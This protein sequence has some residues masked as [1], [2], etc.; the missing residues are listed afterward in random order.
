MT[1]HSKKIITILSCIILF[2]QAHAIVRGVNGI[3]FDHD[4]NGVID[5]TLN[6]TG[7]SIGSVISS[8]NLNI[9][10][11][12]AWSSK[13]IQQNT[14]LGDDSS[15]MILMDTSSGCL[16][17]GL[18]YAANVTGR[19][20]KVKQS[21]GEHAIYLRTKGESIGSGLL[22]NLSITQNS[23][24][25]PYMDLYSDGQQWHILQ[26]H[27]NVQTLVNS[28][29]LIGYWRC[30]ESSGNTIKDLSAYGNDALQQ[31]GLDLSTHTRNG[32]YERG[33]DFGVSTTQH[34]KVVFSDHVNSP[35]P[36]KAFTISLWAFYESLSASSNTLAALGSNSSAFGSVFLRKDADGWFR[37][38]LDD[39][40][41]G[42]A[43]GTSQT[44]A[45]IN[46][47]IHIVGTYDGT[48]IKLYINGQLNSDPSILSAQTT[49]DIYY[50]YAANDERTFIIGNRKSGTISA[51]AIVD[52]VQ[53]Y[54]RALSD[55]EIQLLYGSF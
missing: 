16:N 32:R 22:S 10:G 20:L 41:E 37:L 39:G 40:S 47:W 24:V 34:L 49:Q 13:L 17:L 46:N 52:E 7:L 1:N 30:D 14:W 54:N 11:S 27:G 29:N 55:Q 38:R 8:S 50:N 43:V 42:F 5:M 12:I 25:K 21:S 48:A 4:N 6:N 45:T 26:H 15:S 31:G 44:K 36:P 19:V 33:I 3:Q 2:A 53:L 28:D 9:S 18:P 35:P 23:I 51:G